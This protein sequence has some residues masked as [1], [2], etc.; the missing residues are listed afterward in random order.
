MLILDYRAYTNI[1]GRG[2]NQDAVR[3][4]VRDGSGLF[5]VADGLGGHRNGKAAAEATVGAMF[6]GWKDGAAPDAEQLRGLVEGANDAILQVQRDQHCSCKSTVVALAVEGRRA[7][8]AHTGDSRLYRVREGKLLPLTE[9]HSVAYLKYKTGEIAREQIPLDE[10]QNVLLRALG[11]YKWEPVTGAAEDLAPGDA[12]LLCSDGFW[13]LVSE[14]E[15]LAGRV[16]STGADEW[17]EKMLRRAAEGMNSH[18]E[19]D[20]L[21]VI[22]VVLK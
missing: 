6:D 18:R 21:S 22:T 16:A 15:M 3:A 19:C 2:E 11:G 14:Q 9:D 4:F 20:N 1:G 17:A 10:D 7:A 12:F 13:E 8:W 5:V